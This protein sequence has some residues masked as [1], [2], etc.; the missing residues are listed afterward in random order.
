MK[1]EALM[2]GLWWA[3]LFVP[4]AVGACLG[5][6][7]TERE[8]AEARAEADEAARLLDDVAACAVRNRGIVP[9]AIYARICAF[10][11]RVAGMEPG[12]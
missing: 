12:A 11:D 1:P 5:R 4:F 9:P 10:R 2:F 7:L 3:A 6:K 8:A